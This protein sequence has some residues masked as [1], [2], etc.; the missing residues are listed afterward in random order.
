MLFDPWGELTELG[1]GAIVAVLV[2]TTL[3]V[4]SVIGLAWAGLL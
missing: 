3:I 1:D 4:L 2:I